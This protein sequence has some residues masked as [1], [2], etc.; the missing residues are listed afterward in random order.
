M[1]DGGML[2]CKILLRTASSENFKLAPELKYI[3]PT[4]HV[5]AGDRT[6]DHWL[7]NRTSN[8][9]HYAPSKVNYFKSIEDA[10]LSEHT[11]WQ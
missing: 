8:Q 6:R 4:S 1:L 9:S 11:Y 7:V 5:S 10:S 3:H 2:C